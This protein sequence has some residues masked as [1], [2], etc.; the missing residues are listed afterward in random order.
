M[1][2]EPTVSLNRVNLAQGSFTTTILGS[3]AS[4]TMTPLMFVSAFIQYNSGS[5]TLG[6][7][8]RFRWEYQPGSELFLVYNDQR[9]TLVPSFPGLTNRAVILKI[10]R[11]F[12][13]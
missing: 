5:S 12:R 10:N 1:S 2:I 4:Y 7:N 8:V 6:T 9:D 3:R 11:M 13:L